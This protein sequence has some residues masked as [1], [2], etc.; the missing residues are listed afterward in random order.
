MDCVRTV[1]FACNFFAC[2]GTTFLLVLMYS[3][4]LKPSYLYNLY[5]QALERE[6]VPEALAKAT[7]V[8]AGVKARGLAAGDVMDPQTEQMLWPQIV[9]EALARS[10]VA[11][12]R[13]QHRRQHRAHSLD[14]KNL[15]LPPD[16][17]SSS[18]STSEGS[19]ANAETEG[20]D[21]APAV[22]P[23]WEFEQLEE[24]TAAQLNSNSQ[25]FA[26]VDEFLGADW[27]EL[28]LA[29]VLRLTQS[30]GDGVNAASSGAGASTTGATTATTGASS[31][32]GSSTSTSTSS[33]SGSGS[34]SS[35]RGKR[36]R[37]DL[38]TPVPVPERVAPG[39]WG[40]VLWLSDAMTSS[41]AADYPALAE[42]VTALHALPYELNR[43]FAEL[44]ATLDTHA[45]KVPASDGGGGGATLSP[46]SSPPKGFVAVPPLGSVRLT[47]RSP[48]AP[49]IFVSISS[50]FFAIGAVS[51]SAKFNCILLTYF[52]L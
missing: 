43:Q 48:L 25:G 11:L 39:S 50:R 15:A 38:M 24:G 23:P 7:S 28:V 34:D 19:M 14:P 49:S 9:N 4:L 42:L 51:V 30:G 52:S 2:N 32:D 45:A 31:S 36:A 41:L 17:S 35:S 8:L 12:V 10:V 3:G 37:G 29:D 22:A 1:L 46:A 27:P 16:N 21:L 26:C 40:D 18:G 47:V 20:A 5:L 33:S 44:P 6:A 13:R